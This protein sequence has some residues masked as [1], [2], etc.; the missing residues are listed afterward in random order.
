MRSLLATCVLLLQV[1]ACVR[2]QESDCRTAA[3]EG[4]NAG[5]N[6]AMS[7]GVTDD[8][9]DMA[10]RHTNSPSFAEGCKSAL[11]VKRE[12]HFDVMTEQLRPVMT[13]L[14][15]Q[16]LLGKQAAKELRALPSDC[17]E[18][19][20]NALKSNG[21]ESSATF[22]RT[23]CLEVAYKQAKKVLKERAKATKQNKQ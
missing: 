12:Q 6:W 13:P 18:G 20:K 17:E 21:D 4:H 15:Q 10:G 8:D 1:V 19:Y 11:Q 2:G 5:Y 7:H 22:F 3:C 14:I 23:G 16:Y 9:C